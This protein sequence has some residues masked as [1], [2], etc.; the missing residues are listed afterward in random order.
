MSLFDFVD[1]G[2]G[3][4]AKSLK[5][6][7]KAAGA[8]ERQGINSYA[9]YS[10]QGTAELLDSITQARTRYEPYAKSG[11][12]SFNDWMGTV[13]KMQDPTKF[14]NDI[15]S[16]Y[17]MT[18]A[19]Q[20]RLKMGLDTVENE[21]AA[22]GRLGGSGIK[23]GITQLSQDIIG[24]DQHQYLNDI[25]GI[26]NDYLSN[27]QSGAQ[28]GYDA[29]NSMAGLDQAYGEGRKEYNDIDAN[30][31]SGY[32]GSLAD[33]ERQ[34]AQI[35]AQKAQQQAAAM[36]NWIGQG[37]QMGADYATGG[38]TALI[39]PFTSAYRAEANRPTNNYYGGR[40]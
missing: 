23:R 38:A 14:Y 40:Y 34:I 29:T 8:Y 18:P 2:A 9:D 21:A 30:R 20:Y 33:Q 24:Q 1:G 37:V 7:V 32:Y 11:Q 28:Y 36:N 22:A 27:A 15:M 3:S 19:A 31:Y 13:K 35:K 10:K 5:K 16:G 17:S 6:G 4:A 25:L 12:M 39:R 26:N